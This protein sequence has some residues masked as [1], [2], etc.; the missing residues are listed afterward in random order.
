M[1]ENIVSWFNEKVDRNRMVK[2][3][4]Y[5]AAQAWDQGD[6]PTLLKAKIT[7][8]NSIN[9]HNF[10]HTYSGFTIKAQTAGVMNREKCTIIGLVIMT[11]QQLVRSLIRLGFDTL[12]IFGTDEYSGYETGLTNLLLTNDQ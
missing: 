8:G 9:K 7:W 2:D 10:S 11:D 5:R 3:F 6:A 4:N 1:F 12:Q